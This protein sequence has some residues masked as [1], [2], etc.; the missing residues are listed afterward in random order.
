MLHGLSQKQAPP[1]ARSSVKVNMMQIKHYI[2]VT[3]AC[4]VADS[5]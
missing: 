2:R 4:K 3:D 5:S 1:A